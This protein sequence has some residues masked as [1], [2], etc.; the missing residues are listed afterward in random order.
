VTAARPWA[1]EGT[2][3]LALDFE[4][5]GLDCRRDRVVEIGA[6]RF[7]AVGGPGGATA[8]RE[9]A[10]FAALVDP[11]MPM[12]YQARAI[13]GISDADLEGAPRFASLAPALLALAG[14]AII[15][16]HN[17]PFDISFLES[18]LARAGLASPRNASL[19]T[20]R[21]AKEAFPLE[22]SYRLGSLAERLGIEPGRAHRALDDARACMDL[23]AACASALA[24]HRASRRGPAPMPAAPGRDRA[25]QGRG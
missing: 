11:G 10:A 18:E 25:G 16:A 6:L 22:R 12:P 15:V 9:E 13:H 24:G 3:F 8:F 19:D 7:R 17:A 4:T 1:R 21:L 2:A 23:L 5:T 20:R 14:D